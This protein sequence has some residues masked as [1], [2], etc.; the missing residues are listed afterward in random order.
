VP[1]DHRHLEW[2]YRQLPQWQEKGWIAPEAVDSIKS[3]YG[4]VPAADYRRVT[5]ILFAVLAALLIGGGVILIFAHNWNDISRPLRAVISILPL[6]VT[7]ALGYHVLKSRTESA[8]WREGV[9]V[10][11]IGALAAAVALVGQT[12]SIPGNL[13]S[14]LLTVG[15]LSLPATYLFRSNGAALLYLASL[16]WR[17]WAAAE[18]WI[19]PTTDAYPIFWLMLALIVPFVIMQTRKGGSTGAKLLV[20]GVLTVIAIAMPPNKSDFWC[21]LAYALLGSSIIGLKAFDAEGRYVA[22]AASILS[23]AGLFVILLILSFGDVWSENHFY[24]E[25]GAVETVSL[26]TALAL[27][28]IAVL[29]L[30]ILRKADLVDIIWTA[31]GPLLVL[32]R[33]VSIS[34]KHGSDIAFFIN[35]LG[36]ALGITTIAAGYRRGSMTL[37]NGGLAVVCGIFLMRF[38]D[39]DLSMLLRGCAFIVI[40]IAFIVVNV[41]LSRKFKEERAS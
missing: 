30:L 23:Y 34:N 18:I 6:L 12:Y 40:G 41:K 21:I 14:F 33:L 2:L 16:V 9:A 5:S 32:I 35:A 17:R 39:S 29:A 27:V 37:V 26:L 13:A 31:L 22:R 20:F 36:L 19:G 11:N 24:R 10:G 7:Y 1:D 4:P 28:N 38:F 3:H 25:G 8:V 15:L